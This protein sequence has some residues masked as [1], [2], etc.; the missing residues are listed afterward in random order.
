MSDVSFSEYPGVPK[1]AAW[2]LEWHPEDVWAPFGAAV[3]LLLNRDL[4]GLADLL[5]GQSAE[6]R[7][8]TVVSL[9]RV[10]VARALVAG[11]LM[12]SEFVENRSTFDDGTVGSALDDLLT[13][14][15]PG[16]DTQALAVRWNSQRARMEAEI[17]AACGVQVP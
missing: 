12:N 11:A 15:W 3:R 8:G 2:F 7:A 17:Q 9:L 14:L 4:D 13:F 16:E 5:A 6:P 10:D 1:G